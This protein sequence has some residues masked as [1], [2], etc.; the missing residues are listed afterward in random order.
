[1]P[2][3]SAGLEVRSEAPSRPQGE[4]RGLRVIAPLL[5]PQRYRGVDANRAAAR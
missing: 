4:F 5:N 2:G 3:A 1:M